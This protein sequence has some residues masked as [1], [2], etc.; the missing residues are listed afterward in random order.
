[1]E[2]CFEILQ[3]FSDY[4]FYYFVVNF[5][6]FAGYGAFGGRIC[7]AF[8]RAGLRGGGISI[9]SSAGSDDHNSR[10]NHHNPGSNDNDSY[11]HNYNSCSNNNDP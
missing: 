2:E 4:I 5:R 6:V 1:M 11:N 10:S 9:C 3:V 8:E 7:A